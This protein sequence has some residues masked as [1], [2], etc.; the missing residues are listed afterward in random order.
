MKHVI[1]LSAAIVFAMATTAAY[2]AFHLFTIE[3]VYSNADGTVQFLVLTTKSDGENFWA[4]R[5]ISS[6]NRSFNFTTNLPDGFTKGKR[7]LVA[8]QGFAALGL[9]A[10]DYVIPNNFLQ[11]GSGYVNFAEVYTLSYKSLPTDGTNAL[12]NDGTIARNLATNYAGQTVS[13]AAAPSVPNYQGLWW[14]SPAGAEAGW[15]INFAHQGDSVFASWFTYDLMGKGVWLVMTAAKTGTAAYSGTLFQL[16]GPP[17]DAVPFPALGSP[18]GATG[19]AVG[20]GT[21]TFIDLNSATFAYTVN[22]IAQTKQIVREAFGTLPTC[23]FG[24]QPNLA[25]A[26]NYQDLWWAVPGG[27]ESGWG[28]NLT[29]Q[30][31]TIF[32]SWFTFDR[33][34]SPMWLVVSAPKTA[35]RTYSGTLFQLTGPPFNAVP[36]PPLGSPGGANGTSVGTATFTFSD[37]NSASFAYTVKGTPQTK[38]ITREVFQPPG[39]VCQ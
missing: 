34:R 17:F 4:G 19:A 27:S 5:S 18:G 33:D 21:L 6:L 35:P 15:G 28:I 26:T 11:T 20:A 29:H 38:A 10:P 2:A 22:G 37:G 16:T 36:F 24:A 7:V 31:D 1:R 30:D 32:A 9:I 13:L 14:S 8:S 39:T 25:L 3:Q 23:V 12:F